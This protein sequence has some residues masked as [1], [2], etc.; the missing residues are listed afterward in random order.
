MA[1]MYSMSGVIPEPIGNSH[2]VHTPYNTFDT[3]DDQIIIA[4]IGDKFWPA[5]VDLLDIDDLRNPQYATAQERLAQK[6]MIEGRIS[7]VLAQKPADY[8][9]MKLEQ[10]RVPCARVNNFAQALSD[11]QVRYRN[12]VVE[13]EHPDGGTA[14]VPG[15]PIKLSDVS[16]ETFTSPPLLGAHTI[17]VFREWTDVSEEKISAGIRAGFI[18]E[19]E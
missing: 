6:S 9:L 8:W 13:L 14:E 18:A 19:A 12:M 17:E 1:T 15:N 2:F 11:P 4:V 16:S 7:E 3:K 10:V 5:V